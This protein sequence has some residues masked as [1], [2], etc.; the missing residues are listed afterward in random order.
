MGKKIHVTYLFAML[1]T[2]ASIAQEVKTYHALAL[3]T[4]DISENRPIQKGDTIFEFSLFGYSKPKFNVDRA[5]RV[6]QQ[7]EQI[8]FPSR[9]TGV[10]ALS[11]TGFYSEANFNS[12]FNKIAK[13]RHYKYVLSAPDEDGHI[14][15]AFIYNSNLVSVSYSKSYTFSVKF[16]RSESRNLEIHRV[17]IVAENDSFSVF[18]MF[19]PYNIYID[20]V[21][22]VV[23]KAF[24][25]KQV[26]LLDSMLLK[27][28]N[29][30][31]IIVSNFEYPRDFPYILINFEQ[32]TP[33]F[34]TSV[35]PR[36]N[37]KTGQVI[38]PSIADTANKYHATNPDIRTNI[39][40]RYFCYNTMLKAR[41]TFF[42]FPNNDPTNK[43]FN[44]IWAS[45]LMYDLGDKFYNPFK[46]FAE[47]KN[48]EN[49]FVENYKREMEKLKKK[50]FTIPKCNDCGN[51]FASYVILLKDVGLNGN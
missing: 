2:L 6:A 9:P 26:E 37:A 4:L 24:V 10:D 5:T 45:S 3:G 17:D 23:Q 39:T 18:S 46:F 50:D 7:I 33:R 30:K 35:K 42:D 29:T 11:L 28:P 25:K 40:P 20:S 27:N 13:E 14:A 47:N 16:N 8:A 31:Y 49:I 34:F 48:E 12:L 36:I 15:S 32:V 19:M 44:L 41:N 22:T 38:V 43:K 21:K 1:F 51:R